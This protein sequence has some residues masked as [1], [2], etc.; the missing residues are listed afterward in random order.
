MKNK[1]KC[2]S[3]AS[4]ILVLTLMLMCVMVSSVII[5]SAASGSSRNAR[6][7]AQ[8]QDYLAISSGAQLIADNLKNIG[9]FSVTEEV[10]VPECSKYR[11]YPTQIVPD[12]ETSAI[13]AYWVPQGLLPETTE[14]YI[15][16]E[17]GE[18]T[19]LT[20]TE[21]ASA[22][23]GMMAE[24]LKTA[25]LQ[26]YQQEQP[27]KE[28]FYL[29]LPEEE[30]LPKVKCTFSMNLNYNIKIEVASGEETPATDYRILITMNASRQPIV[31]TSSEYLN[32]DSEGYEHLFPHIHEVQYKY[33]EADQ[34]VTKRE[35]ME[36]NIEKRSTTT[37]VEWS[38]PVLTKG[39][40]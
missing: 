10:I 2:Q 21:G 14:F 31:V 36:F 3:G 28:I 4:M 20:Q 22:L 34:W 27:F 12:G 1:L 25:A 23:T 24:L 33:Y 32:E 7:V 40:D 29:S 8:Q 15:L 16:G 35:T 18:E 5:A 11:V 38:A 6:R 26:V 37:T 13:T 17:L 9:T 19:I 39:V 30:R